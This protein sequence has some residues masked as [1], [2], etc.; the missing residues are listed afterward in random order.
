MSQSAQ[1]T[2]ERQ[3]GIIKNAKKTD[4]GARKVQ[5]QVEDGK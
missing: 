5:K 2:S 1:L 4:Q 3:K